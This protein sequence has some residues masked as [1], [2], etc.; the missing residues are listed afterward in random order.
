[1][2]A[3]MMKV[4]L[5][6]KKERRS[7]SPEE[8]ETE[9]FVD[10]SLSAELQRNLRSN[11][12]VAFEG[13]RYIYKATYSLAGKEELLHLIRTH[14]DGIPSTEVEDSYPTVS[15]DIEELR[16]AGQV[17]KLQN[18]DSKVDILYPN[19][20]R[21]QITVDDDIRQLVHSVK[22]SDWHDMERE[23]KR[24]GMVP[25]T[26]AARRESM[27]ADTSRQGKKRR[28]S[29]RTKY[30]NSHLPELLRGIEMPPGM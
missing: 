28:E 9:T 18:S 6:L 7:L 20:P 8:I 22:L 2:G 29:K 25:A 17:W 4:I 21:I 26:S 15:N 14:K 3:Q 23:L 12:K 10:I 16:S 19:D 24:A 13:G 11:P 27:L 30:T 1:M 5:L